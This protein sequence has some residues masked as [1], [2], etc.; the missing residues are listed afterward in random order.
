MSDNFLGIASP[1]TDY[2]KADTVILPVPYE[3]TT[4]YGKGTAD[5]PAAV[6]EASAYVELY[7]EVY[8]SEAWRR[9]IFTDKPLKFNGNVRQDFELISARV[10][11]HLQNNK[12]IVSLGGEHSITFP[13]LRPF[14]RR[15]PEITVIQFDAHS[16]LRDSYEGT[17]YSHACVM[18]RVWEETARIYQIGIRSQCAEEAVFIRETGIRTLYAHQLRAGWRK[19]L[20]DLSGPVYI[21]FDVDFWDPAVMPATGTPEPGGFFW[22]ETLE[23]LDFIF[24]QCN[25]LGWDMVELSPLKGLSH[26]NFTAAKLIYKMI[27]L[28]WKD[29]SS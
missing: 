13:L 29:E 16:D 2:D 10:D 21:T 14:L 1:Y 4:S 27:N 9:G 24:T 15:F 22:D 25:V 6:I 19:T 26:P 12:C 5:G 7:D 23:M 18:K 17:P 28:K 8:D 3:Q 20:A 11:K